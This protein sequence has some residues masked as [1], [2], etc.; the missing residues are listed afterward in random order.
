MIQTKY[1]IILAVLIV[2][3]NSG[4]FTS[5]PITTPVDSNT[6]KKNIEN[7]NYDHVLDIRTTMEKSVGHLTIATHVSLEEVSTIENIVT[8][9]NHKILVI[10]KN[11]E[12]A[13]LFAEYIS[14][15]G[16]KNVS[17]LNDHWTK[18]I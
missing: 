2:I 14:K 1:I 9:K 6:A 12:R 15:R 17:Y 3:L 4:K 10:S 18:L 13:S 8:D 7:S 11:S 16:Y 5:H